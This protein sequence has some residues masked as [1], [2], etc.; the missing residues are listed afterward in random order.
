MNG[1]RPCSK[2]RAQDWP[3]ITQTSTKHRGNRQAY[4]KLWHLREDP[5]RQ[6]P[7][8]LERATRCSPTDVECSVSRL[9]RHSE[10]LATHEDS[11]QEEECSKQCFKQPPA[12]SSLRDQHLHGRIRLRTLKQCLHYPPQ[13]H[14]LTKISLCSAHTEPPRQGGAHTSR[15]PGGVPR[16]HSRA[17]QPVSHVQ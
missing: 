6:T 2:T 13:R 4:E 14:R 3:K 17:T 11:T 8:L 5:Q 1:D 9:P 16:L 7:R 12:H 15:A 10:R